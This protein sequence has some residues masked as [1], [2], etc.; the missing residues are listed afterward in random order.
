MKRRDLIK[1]G[2]L[3]GLAGVT[4]LGCAGEG[5]RGNGA[6]PGGGVGGDR[7]VRNIIFF[8]YD[9]FNYEDLAMARYFA[10]GQGRGPLELERM[11]GAGAVGSMLTHSLTSV[12][13]DSAAASTAWS[14]GRK[15]V[16]TAL[17]MYP[18][19]RE[20]TTILEL[21]RQAGKA[22]GLITTTRLTH[23][24]PAGWVAKVP[25]RNMEDEIADQY[26]AFQ[27]D[28]LLG[29]GRE[30]FIAEKRA[31]GRDLEGEFGRAGYRVLRGVTDLRALTVRGAALP[32]RVLGAFT[33]D[34]LPYEIDRKFQG[35]AG[36]TLAEITRAGLAV[37]DG[38]RNGFVAQIEAGRI[39]HANHNHDPGA[40]L[41]E[42]L[43][44]DEAMAVVRE[45]VDHRPDTLLIMASDHAT[46][47]QG[48]YGFGP[49]YNMSTQALAT[50][51]SARA[52]QIYVRRNILSVEPTAAQVQ[53]AVR[54]YL[55]IEI[56]DAQAGD[57]VGVIARRLRVGHRSAHATQP[58]NSFYH[59]ISALAPRTPDRPNVN[60]AT[61]A[62]TAGLVPVLTYGAWSGPANL[63]VVDNT[64]LFGWMTRA[65]GSGFR[66]PVM[67]EGEALRLGAQRPPA[68]RDVMQVM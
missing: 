33:E 17:S 37:L 62:H 65:L 20:L 48:V 38:H 60:Y 26:F 51:E 36:P 30:H 18:D 42:I 6:G 35:A 25:D 46:G 8:A 58:S 55:G 67:T 23:A 19:G 11:L 27:P 59:I 63:G 9:G 24:T 10:A 3:A 7:P 68:G 44:A 47:G 54:D 66:N 5:I 39:D 31:D 56:D 50:L 32:G 4:G 2:V 43:A 64:E 34:H 13:T 28:V 16:N 21:A 15:V 1:G 14:T 61:N 53:D 29:G 41:W 49:G 12:V 57:L 40:C 22:T 45:F 52:S